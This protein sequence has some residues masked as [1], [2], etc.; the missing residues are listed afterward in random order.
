MKQFLIMSILCADKPGRLEILAKLIH[1]TGCSIETSRMAVLGS[2]VSMAVQISGTW[3]SIAKLEANIPTL[4]KKHGYKLL[5][6]RSSQKAHGKENLIS[7]SIEL[8]SIENHNI[9]PTLSHFF[10]EQSINIQEVQSNSYISQTGTVMLNLFMRIYIPSRVSIIELRERFLAICEEL[11]V[12]A[13]MEP[14]RI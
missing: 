4:E 7:Y 9:I 10:S 3:D 12:D 5:H 1:S 13:I 2:E 8:I 11:N 6:C 14:E